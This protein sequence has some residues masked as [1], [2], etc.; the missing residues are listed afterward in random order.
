MAIAVWVF[1]GAVAGASETAPAL[2]VGAFVEAY[3]ATNF[4][5][6]ENGV[7][8]L[9]GFDARSGTF[10]LSLA[11][12]HAAVEAD[13]VRGRVA[14]QAGPTALSYFG[15]EP[16]TDAGYAVAPTGAAALHL[17]RE[18]WA[19]TAF[20]G[21]TG[22][23]EL[24][25]GV[26]LS[27]VGYDAIAVKD[28]RFWS[29][30]HLGVGLPFYFTGVRAVHHLPGD[31]GAVTAA[32]FN[33][34]NSI[35]DN[36]RGK[37]GMLSYGRVAESGA[38]FQVLTMGGVEQAEGDDWRQLLDVWADLP[39]GSFALLVG[40]DGG[41][42]I[43][44]DGLHTWQ[45]AQVGGEWS[46]ERGLRAGARFDAFREDGP[47]GLAGAIFWPTTWVGS[48]TVSAG[49]SP[50]PGFLVRVEGRQDRAADPVF[51]AAGSALPSARAQTTLTLGVT[52]WFDG[53]AA[54]LQP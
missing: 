48:G 44:E 4:N 38:E 17:V 18:A 32:V 54:L 13:T 28:N 50:K 21:D 43:R 10:A 22:R 53:Q 49:W 3:G 11:S 24:D 33:G 6:P 46:G 15:A 45:A 30:S 27:P 12:V 42:E 1:T 14:L 8:A 19:G 31:G 39:L 52:G 5:R 26:F 47:S 51:Y 25:A 36:N 2:G 9:R 40:A 35:I 7:T 37:T 29:V 34:W 23:L 20:T 16:A 41:V